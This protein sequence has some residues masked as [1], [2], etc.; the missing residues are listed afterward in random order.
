M[1]IIFCLVMLVISFVLSEVLRPKPELEDAKPAGIGDFKFPTATQGR[2]IPLAWGTV[3]IA[4]P[5]VVWW[6]DLNQLAV[7]DYIKTGMFSGKRIVTGFK[8]HVGV[9]FGLCRGELD[10]VRKVWIKD[11]LVFDGAETSL[12]TI[13]SPNLF[14]GDKL[15]YGGVSG[16]LRVHLG[17]STQV[18]NTYL[19]NE[20][21]QVGG[22]TP[23][24]LG[25]AYLVFEGGYIGNSTSID[26][27]K[28]EVRRIPNGLGLGTPS[29]NSGED[30]NP[31][32]VIYE[33]MTNTEW[34]M[35]VPAA[36]INT[37]DFT[38][39]ATTLAAEGNGYSRLLDRIMEAK[40]LLREIEQQID[41]M[42]YLDHQTGKWRVTLIRADYDIDLIP[43]LNETNIIEIGDFSRGAWRET[44][45]QVRIQFNNRSN[46]YQ[47]DFALAQDMANAMMQGGG[48]VQTGIPVST[49]VNYPGVKDGDLASAIATRDIRP[50]SYPLARA[51]FT[52][53]KSFWDITPG[54]VV[55]WTDGDLGLT[56]LPMR[57]LRIDHGQ[58]DD[59]RMVLKCVQD[60]FSFGPGLYE[61]PP[62]TNWE[63]Q[64]DDLAAFPATEQLAFEAPR[65]LV[66]RDPERTGAMQDKIWCTGRQQDNAVGFLINERHTTSPGTPAGAFTE[67]GESYGLVLIGKLK[68]ALESGTAVPTTSILVEADPDTQAILEAA[69]EDDPDLG[70]QGVNFQNL[71]LVGDE[72]MLPRA[73][74]ISG[75]DV[76][77]DDVYRGVLDGGQAAHA[78][79]DKVYLVFV[80]GN[81]IETTI[82]DGE[83]V[84]VKLYPF[85]STDTVLEGD[86]I[87]VALTMDDR[88]IRPYPPA[89]M[90]LNGTIFDQGTV[91]LDYLAA[92]VAETT[93]IDLDFLRR[94]F[95]TGEGGDEIAALLVDAAT[96]FSDFP[97]NNST[98]HDAEVWN[99]PDGS[100]A[101]LFTEANIAG[102]NQALLRIKILKELDGSIPSRMRV[103][104][105]A[106]H[107]AG[108]KT[109]LLSR[110]NLVFDFDTASAALAGQ[111]NFTA[112]DTNDVSAVYTADAAG[113]HDF[114]LS[115]A[116][117]VGNVEYRL[118]SGSWLALVTAG[119]TTGNIAGVSISDT[120]EIRHLSTDT[121]AL[122]QIDMVAPG[123]GTDAYGILF[124]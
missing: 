31:M 119:G 57:V 103:V 22:V 81:L 54:T 30:A 67:V 110:N 112:L 9:Q 25:T 108:G 41:G 105:T 60:V 118:N 109:G 116:F 102:T 8:Y 76:S 77:L 65:A 45:N 3:Q 12:I 93:G 74:S 43:Q 19:G 101:L 44:T 20:G 111:F 91:S 113:Q 82:P 71:I 32:N 7:T 33:L 48:T 6:G 49:T 120:I 37:T 2:V 13:N 73:A 70:D 52:V 35:G 87:Q 69:F 121:S 114:T 47:E 124:T 38:S 72:F 86:A 66:H 85:S 88:L 122:K 17:S 78:A 99:D 117:T 84:H 50:L 115:S 10:N 75:A 18:A 123:A 94:D 79:A 11:K 63:P 90:D 21:Q 83:N 53:D 64:E 89:S 16:S 61:A 100:P 80:G 96:V 42:V 59:N 46:K 97:S 39:A 1:S 14:G 15:G 107:D 29:V 95:R 24:Y 106:R 26:P 4:G 104:L 36:D 23:R 56:K 34:G 28:F 92:G 51:N 5:N 27:W 58:L 62:D 68:S 98:D 55:A 40:D